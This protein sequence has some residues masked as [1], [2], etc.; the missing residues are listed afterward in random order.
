MKGDI[1]RQTGLIIR[2]NGEYLVGRQLCDGP[3]RW[4]ISPYDAYRTRNREKAQ[5]L[6]RVTGGIVLLFNPIIGEMRIL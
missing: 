4:S 5:N 3:L 2:K 6:A 1:R